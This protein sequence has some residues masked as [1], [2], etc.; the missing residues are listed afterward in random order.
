MKRRM[1]AGAL[2]LL[3]LMCA[4]CVSSRTSAETP[5]PANFARVEGGAFQMGINDGDD[6]YRAHTVTV[7]SFYM[8]K[9]EVT[10]KEWTAVMGNNPSE[11]KG[12]NLPA[13][14]V[15]WYDAVEYCNKRSQKEGLTPAYTIDKSRE[16][17]NNKNDKDDDYFKW[18]V[19]WNRNANG[20]RLPT[21]AEWEYAARGGDGSPGNYDYAGSN[22]VDE[23][24]WHEENS[25][26]STQEAGAKK[27]N[28]LG[29][30][31]MSG[32]VYEWCWDWYDI[33]YYKN[34]PQTDPIG[35]SSG[36]SRVMRGGFWGYPAEFAL[37]AYR[38]SAIPSGRDGAVGFR[39]VRNGQ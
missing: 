19:R 13:E 15:S 26:G 31:D 29:L 24:A 28:G 1:I 4:A 16:D 32:N 5:V 21:E 39:V 11:F 38:E 35:A 6:E 34:S 3:A 9:Y 22:N 12:D 8:G 18:T 25:A 37:S 7:K 10:Q 2:V 23:V 36:S 20:Y 30:Y 27:P 14:N 33:D 17:Y